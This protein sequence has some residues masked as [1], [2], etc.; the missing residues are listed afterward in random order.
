MA[1]RALVV[2]VMSDGADRVHVVSAAALAEYTAPQSGRGLP[3]DGSRVHDPP[4]MGIWI[5]LS[6]SLVMVI[7]LGAVLIAGGNLVTGGGSITD[8][9]MPG[10][11]V[12]GLLVLGAGAW[13]T[14][15]RRLRAAVVWLGVIG[16]VGA[17]AFAWVNTGEMQTRDLL[18]YVGIPSVVMLLA[19]IGV[20]VGRVRAGALGTDTA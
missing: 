14:D 8:P 5:R 15:A 6:R 9:V 12:F 4:M 11:V 19:A 13:T 18:V 3:I 2:A 16:I 17:L 10:G 20:A 1:A 7:G